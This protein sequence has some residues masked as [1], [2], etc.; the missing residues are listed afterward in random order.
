MRYRNP[1]YHEV[2]PY[3]KGF[4]F[5]YKDKIL[6][7]Q[8]EME[9]IR[10]KYLKWFLIDCIL[11]FIL[12]VVVVKWQI[13][14]IDELKR[15]NDASLCIHISIMTFFLA[16]ILLFLPMKL[17][18]K[19]IK[20]KIFCHVANFF[21]DFKYIP[22]KKMDIS[23]LVRSNILPAHN[24]YKGEDL[25]QGR[26]NGIGVQLSEARLI[27]NSGNNSATAFKGLFILFDFK[28]SQNKSKTR[29]IGLKDLGKFGNFF[30]IKLGMKKVSLEDPELEKVFEFFADDQIEARVILDPAFM[31]RLNKFYQFMRETHKIK[32]IKFSFYDKKLFIMMA[33]NKNFFE[34]YKVWKTCIDTGYVR[35]FL[36]EMHMIIEIAEILKMERKYKK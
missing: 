33:S 12:V 13:S 7:L 32:N 36:Q 22:K 27:N 21:A 2:A 15:R 35:S 34:N 30:N 20:S 14:I 29:V 18:S 17:Y 1:K 25:I 5:Y 10:Y 31:D 26:V 4:R 9:K 23:C 16:I 11:A 28:N 19:K 3:E 8:K 24:T 6:P